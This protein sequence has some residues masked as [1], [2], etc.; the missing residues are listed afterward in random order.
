[1]TTGPAPGDA[2]ARLS[3]LLVVVGVG[4]VPVTIAAIGL[5]PQGAVRAWI[6]LAGLAVTAT[7]SIWAGLAGRRALSAGTSHTARAV[8]ASSLGFVVGATAALMAVLSVAGSV[9]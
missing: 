4:F 1:V 8:G 6:Y 9:L 3:V 2:D 7:V 5:A